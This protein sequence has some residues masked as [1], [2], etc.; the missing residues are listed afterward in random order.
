V[1][2]PA[3]QAEATI[4]RCLKALGCQTVDRETYE[5]LLVDDGSTD[6]TR[7]LADAHPGIHRCSQ[8]HAGPAV[9]RNLGIQQARGEI[10]LFTD[11]DCEPLPDWI[12]QMSTPFQDQEIVGAKGAYFTRQSELVARFVQVEYEEKYDWMA[13]EQYI[14]FIDTYAAGYRRNVLLEHGGFDPVFPSASVEDQE[15]SFRLARQ[16]YKMVFVS[17]ARVYHWGHAQSLSTYL[18]RK[19]RIGYWK[20]LIAWRY[21]DKLA[22]DTHTPHM[23]K[24]QIFLV[25]L[26]LVFLP[27]SLLLPIFL[28][29]SLASGLAFLISTLPFVARAWRQDRPVALVAPGL[30][31]GR[32]LALGAGFAVGVMAGLR[33]IL[34]IGGRDSA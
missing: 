6:G 23:L 2:V 5:I 7:T 17:K 30:L 11:A 4:D 24:L 22:R 27:L 20:S 26:G 31:F 19:F 21:P 32:A 15:L 1:V 10:V 29:G 14:D 18:K 34:G 13:R 8:S 3:Y 28:W 33:S 25:G 16:G 12:E 9:A